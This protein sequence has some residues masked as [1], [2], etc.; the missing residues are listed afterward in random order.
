[1][2]ARAAHGE[3]TNTPMKAITSQSSIEKYFNVLDLPAIGPVCLAVALP[4]AAYLTDKSLPRAALPGT[5]RV[6]SG[7]GLRRADAHAS[8]LGEAAELLSCCEWGDE[9]LIE[10]AADR[11]G[12]AALLPQM[13]SGLSD[14]QYSERDTWNTA[15]ATFDWRPKAYTPDQGIAWTALENA[16]QNSFA[17]ADFM[18]IGRRSPGDEQ[19][20]AIGDSNGCA[21]GHT[22]EQAKLAALLEIIERDAVARWWYG[23]RRRPVINL[24]SLQDVS[25]LVKWLENRERHCFLFDVT[26]DL[27]VPVAAAAS[28]EPD[29]RDVV[30]GFAAS[31]ELRKA[32]IG[33]LSEMVQLEFSLNA[34]RALGN[35]AGPWSVWRS[36]VTMA[37]PPLDAALIAERT[38]SIDERNIS[39]PLTW[40]FECC[41]GA[42]VAAFFVEMTR[43]RIGIPALRAISCDLCVI[44]P[45]FARKRLL[46]PDARDLYP[47]IPDAKSQIPLLV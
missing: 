43:A 17:P 18:L 19:A 22:I 9:L 3:T 34:A 37:M 11:L 28:S 39:D 2:A 15:W 14:K 44:K 5:G 27:G 33:A 31:A 12:S 45:R 47:V 4:S 26:S 8:C 35:S 41:A 38:I 29:G 40:L 32:S 46:A 10:A 20:V 30:L 13:L 36:S 25:G 16:G 6:A 21:A 23:R 1:M 24:A 7:R 42:G